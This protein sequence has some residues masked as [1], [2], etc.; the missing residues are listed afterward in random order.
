MEEKIGWDS[1]WWLTDN[2]RDQKRVSM[3]MD[4]MGFTKR[5]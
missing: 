2:G 5:I 4:N 1:D 3:K